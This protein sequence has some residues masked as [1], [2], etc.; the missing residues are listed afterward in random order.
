LAHHGIKEQ[1]WGVRRGPPYPLSRTSDG[2]LNSAKQENRKDRSQQSYGFSL[3][4]KTERFD[5]H[6]IKLKKNE[7]FMSPIVSDMKAVNPVKYGDKFRN[8]N[9][10]YCSLAYDLRR[11]GY[12]VCAPD[13]PE[14]REKDLV[15]F[16][17]GFNHTWFLSEEEANKPQV[18]SAQR[19]KAITKWATRELK[20]QGPGARGFFDVTFGDKFGHSMIYEVGDHGV[21][22]LDTQNNKLYSISQVAQVITDVGYCRVDNKTPNFA[23]LKKKGAYDNC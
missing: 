2:R 18:P 5:E 13:K 17:E 19:A 3:T 12:D 16:Y 8:R 11:R 4:K 22:I 6:G 23:Y 9:C 21:M 7:V 20:A 14:V 15:K 10:P 1:Q